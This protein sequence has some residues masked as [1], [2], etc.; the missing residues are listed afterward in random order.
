[1]A[2]PWACLPCLSIFGLSCLLSIHVRAVGA[3]PTTNMGFGVPE[4]NR[5][6]VT[7]AC[8]PCLVSVMHRHMPPDLFLNALPARRVTPGWTAIPTVRQPAQPSRSPRQPDRRCRCP[9]RWTRPSAR[10]LCRP[11]AVSLVGPRTGLTDRRVAKIAAPGPHVP[12]H[13]PTPGF[14]SKKCPHAREPRA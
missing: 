8:Q 3:A 10:G 5:I 7:G 12:R 1:M 13:C 11:V 9:R 6:M 4:C 14:G 2:N